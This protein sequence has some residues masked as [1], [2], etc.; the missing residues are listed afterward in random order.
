MAEPEV[1][2]KDGCWSGSWRCIRRHASL[3]IS[4]KNKSLSLP[5]HQ[6]DIWSIAGCT[7]GNAIVFP[8]GGILC[9]DDVSLGWP[10]VFYITGGVSA[11]WSMLWIFFARNYPSQTPGISAEEVEYIEASLRHRVSMKR[12][13][14]T[15]WREMFTSRPVFAVIATHFLANFVLYMLLTKAP[16]Y[17]NEILKLDIKANGVYSMLPIICM[18]VTVFAGGHICDFSI[19]R[20]IFSVGVSRKIVTVFGTL[21]PGIFMVVLAQAKQGQVAFA[22][23]F[24]CLTLGFMGFGFSS[25]VI[26]YGDIA[27]QYAGTLSGIGNA[28]S[29]LPGIVAPY[30]VSELTPNGT[31]QEWQLAFYVTAAIAGLSALVFILFGSGELQPWAKPQS[32][33]EVIFIEKP[34]QNIPDSI[35][36]CPKALEHSSV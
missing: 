3:P 31:R 7:I 15:P 10:F 18:G 2:C 26:N 17:F 4:G 14:T 11:I 1:R 12:V 34:N 20:K 32:T 21:F 5:G 29:S 19:S 13:R 28:I 27:L 16:T 9:D 33:Q 24:M 22:V 6:A 23:S 36:K 8:L 30:V 35:V 25:Y